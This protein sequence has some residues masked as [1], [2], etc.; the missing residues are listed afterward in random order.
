MPFCSLLLLASWAIIRARYP[1]KLL[2]LKM[3]ELTCKQPPMTRDQILALVVTTG[4]VRTALS[5]TICVMCFYVSGCL[6]TWMPVVGWF[7]GCMNELVR[8]VYE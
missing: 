2:R 3:S 8:W 1:P 7:G 5:A 6:C 4:T